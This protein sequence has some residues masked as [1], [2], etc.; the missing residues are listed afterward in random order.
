MSLQTEKSLQ[1]DGITYH[2]DDK[3]KLLP[4]LND[5]WTVH[6]IKSFISEPAF[7]PFNEFFDTIKK[8]AQKY[9]YLS[10]DT[11]YDLITAWIISTYFHRLFFSFPF[12]HLKAPKGSGKSQVLGFLERLCFNAI[13]ARP[14]VASMGDIVTSLRCTFLIDQADSLHNENNY[15]IREILTDSYKKDGGKRRVLDM[16]N[17]R[18]QL[19]FETFSP[20]AF[21]STIELPEDLKDRCILIPLV[22]SSHIFPTPDDQN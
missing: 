20:K 16:K 22:R 2:I 18:K 15:E 12:L 17:G 21:A 8:T 19:E 9:F 14:T 5:K 11:D 6:G 10:E 4:M 1:S 13:K 7:P 3:D